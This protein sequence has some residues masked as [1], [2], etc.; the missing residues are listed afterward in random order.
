M[1]LGKFLNL[2]V[3]FHSKLLKTAVE[4]CLALGNL[5]NQWWCSGSKLVDLL[6]KFNSANRYQSLQGRASGAMCG[7]RATSSSLGW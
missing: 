7:L 1:S 5:Q 6:W 2:D 3:Y 4:Q